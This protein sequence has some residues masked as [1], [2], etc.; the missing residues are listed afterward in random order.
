[1]F[2]FYRWSPMQSWGVHMSR[3]DM[4]ITCGHHSFLA[5]GIK[6]FYW[7]ASGEGQKAGKTMRSD[8]LLL[9]ISPASQLLKVGHHSLLHHLYI[10]FAIPMS[11]E[12]QWTHTARSSARLRVSTT[13]C[14]MA[15]TEWQE[16]WQPQQATFSIQ[17]RACFEHR[18]KEM[19]P[20]KH[21]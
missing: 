20:R 2:V 19:S 18:K 11:T 1:M 16:S 17:V 5:R 7:G 14:I 13:K 21:D 4:G 3:A 6:P 12:F 15:T 9:A 8:I 10:A